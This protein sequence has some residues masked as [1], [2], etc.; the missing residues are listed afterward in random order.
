LLALTFVLKIRH[1]ILGT[2]EYHTKEWQRSSV[3]M[4]D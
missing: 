4:V 3:Q 2:S 1:A